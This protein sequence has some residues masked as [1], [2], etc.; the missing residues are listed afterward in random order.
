M[1]AR[2]TARLRALGRA[3]RDRRRSAAAGEP[4][5]LRVARRAVA[6]DLRRISAT[7]N[8]ERGPRAS[9]VYARFSPDGAT[10]T[11][12]DAGRRAV[13]HARAGAGLI[14]ATRSGEERAGVGRHRHRRAGVDARRAQLRRSATCDNHFAVAVGAERGAGAARGRAPERGRR[15]LLLLP[16]AREPA[17]RGARAAS[18]RCGAASLTAAALMLYNPLVLLALLLAVLAAAVGA[19]VG[20]ALARS[21]RTACDRRAADRAGQRARQPRAG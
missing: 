10:L 18:A 12:L 13:Q 9:G 4:E 5:T 15:T 3:R 16:P 8:L 6:E 17:A 1:H 11:L 21:L 20:G 14:A 19:G 2:S 7:A